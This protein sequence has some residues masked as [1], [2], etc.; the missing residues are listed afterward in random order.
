MKKIG[1]WLDKRMA[2]IISIDNDGKEQTCTVFSK[3]DDHIELKKAFR[4]KV[5]QGPKEIIKDRKL[6]EY[7]K[8]ALK[9]YFKEININLKGADS[10]VVFGPA[11]I[12]K[13]FIAELKSINL[14]LYNKVLDVLKADSM[15][16]N[17]TTALIRDYYSA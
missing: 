10:L 6:I 15:T 2:Y 8:Q 1:V 7:D 14:E 5:K 13:K 3:T 9:D 16:A 11:E 4:D 17:Q 12:P